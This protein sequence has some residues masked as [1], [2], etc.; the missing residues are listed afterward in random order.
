MELSFHWILFICPCAYFLMKVLLTGAF[1]NV[2]QRTLELLL[3]K[4]YSVRCFDLR[5]PRNVQIETRMRK[6]GIFETVWGDIRDSKTT[7]RI[8]K[9]VD[10]I[11]HLAAI[12]PPLAYE[13][14]ALAYDV[15][16]KGSI[17]LLRAAENMKK[18]PRF[19]YVSSIAVHG[20]RMNKEPPTRV[21]DPLNPLDYD[22]YAKHKIEVEKEIWKSTIPWIILRFAAVTPYEMAW[23]IPDLMYE[24]PLEQR[25]EL[26]DSRDAGLACVNALNADVVGKILFIGGGKG[27]QLYQK[28]FVSKMLEVLSI[29]MLPD[30]AFKPVDSIEDYYHCDWMN[31]TEAQKLLNFQRYTFDDFLKEFKKKVSFRRFVVKLFKPLVRA[32]LLEKSPYYTKNQK[33]RTKYKTRGKPTLT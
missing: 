24:V 28:E 33:K 21:D 22:N 10:A 27:N 30:N 2:G 18:P 1:G 25:I 6:L 32:I 4:G 17:N 29:G 13:K 7:L 5:N 20:N 14:Q 9:D 23:K 3:K 15:N 31:T 19:V 11:I 26:V 16:V 8:V 12:I